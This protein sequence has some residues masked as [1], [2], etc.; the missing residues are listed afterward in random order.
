MS[1]P[2]QL[3]KVIEA[4]KKAIVNFVGLGRPLAMIKLGTTYID[5]K[6]LLTVVN[7]EQI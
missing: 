4:M 2:S 7:Y 6:W 3:E 1:Q 5:M